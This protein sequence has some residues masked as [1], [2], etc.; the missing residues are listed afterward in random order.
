MGSKDALVA[1]RDEVLAGEMIAPHV[2]N[3]AL[4]GCRRRQDPR[5]DRM[6]K[7]EV[8]ETAITLPN[9]HHVAFRDFQIEISNNEHRAAAAY[10]FLPYKDIS[11]KLVRHLGVVHWAV[12]DKDENEAFARV[13]RMS[14][15]QADK[16]FEPF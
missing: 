7:V 12:H 14:F 15:G 9:L 5:A 11:K 13:R 4:H 8:H 1:A 2:V 6:L 3:A 16:E 10:F